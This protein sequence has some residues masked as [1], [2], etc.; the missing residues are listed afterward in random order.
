MAQRHIHLTYFQ[1]SRSP[2]YSLVFAIPLLMAYEG[3]ALLLN[4]S[5][6]YGI[7]NSADVFLKL[8]LAYMG[9]HGFFGFGVAMIVAM[10]LFR[11][12]GG[13]PRFGSIR[14]GVLVWMLAESLVYSLVFGAVVSAITHVLLAQPFLLSRSAQILVSLGAGIYE[15]FVFR[16]LLL[17]ALAFFLHRLLR[18]QERLAYGMAAVLG[19]ALFSAFHYIG[20]FGEPLQLPSFMFRFI[21]GLLLTAL[22][23][24]RGYGITAYTHSLYDL[25]ITFGMI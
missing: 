7:R 5:D 23:F 13:G 24:A 1:L 14:F 17:A 18:L 15:E 2:H 11:L 10:I 25:W 21:A 22:Y 9:I 4:H 12:V 19:A 16:V 8:F 6:L 3:F 20:P